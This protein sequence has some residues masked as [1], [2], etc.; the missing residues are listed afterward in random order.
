[1]IIYKCDYCENEATANTMETMY[2]VT[3]SSEQ[4]NPMDNYHET[5]ICKSCL[6]KLKERIS[7]ADYVKKFDVLQSRPGLLSEEIEL[8]NDLESERARAYAKGWNNAIKE[9][10]TNIKVLYSKEGRK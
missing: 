2:K 7:N 4:Y 10:N 8:D 9:Y 3:E 5:L 6:N 1:M